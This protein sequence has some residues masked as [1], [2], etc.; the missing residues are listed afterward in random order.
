MAVNRAICMAQ[1]EGEITLFWLAVLVSLGLTVLSVV[2]YLICFRTKFEGAPGLASQYFIVTG[3]AKVLMGLLI[4][5]LFH[6]SCP[7]NCSL[8]VCASQNIPSPVY[9]MTATLAGLVWLR[10]GYAF[11]QKAQELENGDSQGGEDTTFQEVSTVEV[12]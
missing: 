10:K 3:T 2:L 6:P 9:A 1:V 7:N 12:V 8:E 5:G 4:A 11:H